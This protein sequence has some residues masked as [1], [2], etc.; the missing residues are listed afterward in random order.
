[1]NGNDLIERP[2]IGRNKRHYPLGSA[3]ARVLKYRR[4][5]GGTVRGNIEHK[6]DIG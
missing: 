5:G 2:D 6:Q 3:V 4:G 1:M